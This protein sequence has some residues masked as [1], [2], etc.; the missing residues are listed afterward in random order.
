MSYQQIAQRIA[1]RSNVGYNN[2]VR[3]AR[4]EGHRVQVQSGM[5]ACYKAKDKGANV[6]KQWD[7]ALDKRTRES[8]AAVDGEIRELDEKFS[9]GLRFPGDPHG[10]AAEVV[11][12]RC[13]LLQRA[14]WA[15]DDGELQTLKDRAA[16][17]GLDKADTFEDYKKKY[18]K[19]AEVL[20]NAGSDDKI[21]NGNNHAPKIPI[22]KLLDYALNPSKA[23]DKAKAFREALGYDQSNFD[24][25]EQ[26]ILDHIDE[27]M[28]VEKGDSGY[29][30]RYEYIMELT[31]A[32]G[33]KAN[34]LTA[35][36]QYGNH[37]RLTSLYVTKRKATK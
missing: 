3:I 31:G 13:A 5:D 17:F 35:W 30:M 32:N 16:Y 22:S 11:N 27:S 1:A 25:L 37:K 26:N 18:L 20:T 23:P 19:A 7:A 8:H 29:G 28:F 6:V 33:K 36:M 15:L 24:A 12:C 4:T 21:S 10:K 14:R 34:V 2:A 9:N